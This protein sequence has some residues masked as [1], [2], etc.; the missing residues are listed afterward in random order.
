[1]NDILQHIGEVYAG[2]FEQLAKWCNA[3]GIR[4]TAA[5]LMFAY[6]TMF[7]AMGLCFLAFEL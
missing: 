3:V 7:A 2:I 6:T 5:D 4:C 1:M